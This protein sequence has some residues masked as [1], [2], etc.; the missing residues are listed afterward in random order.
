MTENLKQLQES[1]INLFKES[2][3]LFLYDFF[4]KFSE[5]LAVQIDWNRNTLTLPL[6]MAKLV[7][8]C[9]ALYQEGQ[10][11]MVIRSKIREEGRKLGL[12]EDYIKSELFDILRFWIQTK[13]NNEPCITISFQELMEVKI[14][15]DEGIKK[16]ILED[17]QLLKQI[18]KEFSEFIRYE[19]DSDTGRIRMT[20]E[21]TNLLL[22]IYHIKK[23]VYPP[24]K[25][26]IID[27]LG[28]VTVVGTGVS[29]TGLILYLLDKYSKDKW[30]KNLQETLENLKFQLEYLRDTIEPLKRGNI[31]LTIPRVRI[32]GSIV[33]TID[34]GDLSSPKFSPNGSLLAYLKIHESEPTSEVLISELYNNKQ[35]ILLDHKVA[36]KYDHYNAML[37]EMEWINNRHLKVLIPAGD[38]GGASLIFDVPSRKILSIQT[39]SEFDEDQIPQDRREAI[40]TARYLFGD[41]IEV[42]IHEDINYAFLFHN[43][44]VVPK[45]GIVL[46]GKLPGKENHI[47]FLDF[48]ERSKKLLVKIGKEDPTHALGG[49]VT[50]GTSMIFLVNRGGKS[51]LFVYK[52]GIVRTLTEAMNPLHLTPGL[53]VKFQS[54]KIVIFLVDAYGDD[55]IEDASLFAFDGNQLKKV[56]DFPGLYEADIDQQGRRIAFCVRGHNKHNIIVK[57]LSLVDL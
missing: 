10:D 44:F 3:F 7:L 56:V 4:K 13:T 32:S 9:Y 33:A 38:I 48:E 37:F 50:L 15:L 8:T 1:I 22:K 52:D 31:D 14:Q 45:R 20:N 35:F 54:S 18:L 27:K 41:Q 43:A 46:Q 11:E 12:P 5:D 39:W 55:D 19:V 36:I 24:S 28:I 29:I 26:W 17:P 30:D 47:W 34:E 23:T 6:K 42:E 53:H 2:P 51:Y 21:T 49:G 16:I 57:E 25:K 40:S